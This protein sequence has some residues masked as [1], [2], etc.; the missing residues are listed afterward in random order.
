MPFL[1]ESVAPAT[2]EFPAP[3]RYGGLALRFDRHEVENYKRSLIGLS[4]L[5]RGEAPLRFMA[6]E[7]VCDHLSIN[8]RT[9]GRRVHGRVR[10]EEAR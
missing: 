2:P 10:G 1:P 9:L 6:A 8:R 5:E 3:F 4:A 7:E